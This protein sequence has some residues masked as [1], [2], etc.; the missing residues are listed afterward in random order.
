MRISVI[1]VILHK[2]LSLYLN[3]G[4]NQNTEVFRF[5]IV[6]TDN[7]AYE[8]RKK[9]TT[10]FTHESKPRQLGIHKNGLYVGGHCNLFTPRGSSSD[11]DIALIL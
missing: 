10:P 3:F 2:K 6:A 4:E 5:N 7:I 8:R 1:G 9:T 11:T